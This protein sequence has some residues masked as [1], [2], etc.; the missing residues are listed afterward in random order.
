M[1]MALLRSLHNAV[2]NDDLYSVQCVLD[3]FLVS[4]RPKTVYSDDQLSHSCSNPYKL[5][6]DGFI[7][8]GYYSSPVTSQLLE[9]K[10]SSV[11]LTLLIVA[12]SARWEKKRIFLGL[13]HIPCMLE[14]NRKTPCASPPSSIHT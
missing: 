9:I 6:I 11:T 12:D 2:S 1:C 5:H 8:L 7:S 14:L 13:T 10:I 4:V 3:C